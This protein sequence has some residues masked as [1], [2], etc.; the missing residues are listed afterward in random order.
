ME[1]RKPAGSSSKYSASGLAILLPQ[2]GSC[3]V[4]NLKVFSIKEKVVFTDM[5]C[6]NFLPEKKL[7][8]WQEV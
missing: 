5:L 3:N 1:Y 6:S 7:P 4:S 8:S 2:E